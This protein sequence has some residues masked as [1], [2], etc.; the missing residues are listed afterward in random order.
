MFLPLY[1]QALGNLKP[2]PA[3][4]SYFHRPLAGV[5]NSKK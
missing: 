5:L 1:L 2:V 3:S 4:K